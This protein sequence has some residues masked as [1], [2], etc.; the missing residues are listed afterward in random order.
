MR[1]GL[2]V[3]VP[4]CQSRGSGFKNEGLQVKHKSQ[5]K[6][7]CTPLSTRLWWIYWLYTVSGKM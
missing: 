4:D 7:T 5:S 1:G 2:V 3:S 6:F